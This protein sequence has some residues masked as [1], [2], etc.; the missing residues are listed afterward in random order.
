MPDDGRTAPGLHPITGERSSA[1]RVVADA[2]DGAWRVHDPA[3]RLGEVGS[4]GRAEPPNGPQVAHPRVVFAGPVLVVA[5]DFADS[6]TPARQGPTRRCDLASA[7]Y[8]R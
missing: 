3:D 8:A 4:V 5:E 7:G 1:Q 2:I 6:G